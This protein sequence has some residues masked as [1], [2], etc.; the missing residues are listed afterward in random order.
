MTT[1][2]DRSLNTRPSKKKS[3]LV[4]R[5]LLFLAVFGFL[6]VAACGHKTKVQAPKPPA[7][8]PPP[9]VQAA[10]A[11]PA[12]N[13]P[14]PASTPSPPEPGSRQPAPAP[15]QPVSAS[16]NPG[17]PIRI[18][19]TT[20]ARE[21]HITAPGEF[22]LLEKIPEAARV[23]VGGDLEVRVER[24]SGEVREVYRVQVGAFAR[25]ESAQ[26]LAEKIR[27]EFSL[28][29][30][31]RDHRDSGI[32]QVR[33][34][35]FRTRKDAEDFAA[36]DLAKGGYSD[37]MVVRESVNGNDS[38]EVRLALRGP[39]L[40]RVSRAGFLFQPASETGY[41]RL[42]GKPYRGNLDIILNKNGLITV[43]NQLGT[44]EYLLGVVPAELS[45]STYP[46]F[47]A[48]AAQSI[49]ARTYAL[50][51]AGRFAGDGFDLTADARTQVYGGVAQ[52]R[53][54]ASK[55]VR[56]TYGISIYYQGNLI[57]AMYMS[58]CGGRTEDFANVFDS[59]PV[60]YLRGVA[61]AIESAVN[62]SGAG[63][64][65]SGTHELDQ[66]LFAEDGSAANR[67][68]ELGRLIGLTGSEPVSSGQLFLPANES[69]IRRWVGQAA[70]L[71]GKDTGHAAA[72]QNLGSRAGFARYAAERLMGT[73]E[74]QRRLTAGD[75]EYYLSNLR[76]GADVPG[77]A[78]QAVALLFQLG[79]W[80]P[81]PDNSVRP[82]E[83]IRRGDALSL[84]SR[85]VEYSRP[86]ILR[87]GLFA[88]SG[89]SSGEQPANSLTVKWGN[90]ELQFPL[91][92]D[93]RLFKLAE[94]RST[95]ADSLRI[96]GNEKL[97]FHVTSDGRMDFLEVELNPTGAS[98][99]RYS[100]VATWEIT[101]PRLAAAEKLRPM[102][103]EIGELLDLQIS[104]TGTS[105]RAIQMKA[106]GRRGTVFLN[107]YKV[108]NALGLRD[109]LFTI[110][111]A[112][113]PSGGVESFTFKGRGWGHGVG[114][115]QV[116]AYGMARAGGTYEEILKT[117][118]QGVE[119]RRAY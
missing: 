116:G 110:R 93:L 37:A 25:L 61:C 28:P 108:R 49:A 105:G 45:P 83:P 5:I 41:L 47:A 99:D 9:V 17:P 39:D 34:G 35:E 12:P 11:R 107:G 29:A 81:Y 74:I 6:L 14:K 85:W 76:D 52:E 20:G 1:Y 54:L 73:A 53:D 68:I 100:P 94:G 106:I 87:S 60:P 115:C 57:D 51:N 84:L 18:G 71:G 113:D 3:P 72:E 16:L 67:N 119:L 19:L 27:R 90:K 50:K 97:R 42:D 63:T 15:S 114:L 43:V 118:Y 4:R 101:V 66:P 82:L 69:E 2:V 70:K 32:F 7:N 112:H 79:L 38:A 96:I 64:L 65:V 10:P 44:E 24:G 8:P 36:G 62:G 26:A 98:S 58:T 91:A 89:N 48:L 59:A 86:E 104:R 30:F 111:R 33:A 109:T 88:G 40:F 77:V 13:V 21:I 78:R 55:A 117:Y 95:P 103:G 56:A 92:V 80:R 23:I 22:F 31:V 75:T 46:E 102:T